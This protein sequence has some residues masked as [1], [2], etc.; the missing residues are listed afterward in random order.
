MSGEGRDAPIAWFRPS[1]RRSLSIAWLQAVAFVLLGA[2]VLGLLRVKRVD[3]GSPWLAAY[4]LGMVAVMCGP[5]WL[6]TRLQRILRV[7]R[8]LVLGEDGVRWNVGDEVSASFR[9]EEL[10]RV[11]LGDATIVIA[12]ADRQL[13]LPL[14]FDGVDGAELVSTICDLQRKKLLGV[15]LRVRLDRS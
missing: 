3:F 15:P 13:E 10:E 4:I 2:L 8:V 14:P 5:L 1:V 12:G 6:A 9:W 11:E 7:E